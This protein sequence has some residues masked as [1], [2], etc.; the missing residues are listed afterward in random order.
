MAVTTPS[1]QALQAVPS[2]VG[3]IEPF[4]QEVVSHL[5]PVVHD[6]PGRGRPRILPAVVLWSGLLVCI[7]RGF[8]SQLALWRLLSQT[9]L[10]DYPRFPITDQAVYRRL[11]TD[12]IAPLEGLFRQ[13]TAL[14]ATRLDALLPPPEQRLAPFARDV[15]ALDAVRLDPV[16][17]DLSAPGD[18]PTGRR[19]PGQLGTLFDLRRQQWRH[20]R[21]SADADQNEKVVA[22]DLLDGLARG[23]LILAD[24]GY[25]G[26]R[27]FDELTDA[28]Y[29]WVSRLRHKTSYEVVAVLAQHGETLDALV[30][31]GVYR[32][33]RAKH[34]VRLVQ[35]R[36]GG[37][38]RRY[39]TNVRDPALLPAAEVARLYARRW[40]IELAFKLLKREVG[41]CLWWST[42][43][44]VIQQQLLGALILS[45]IILA[46]R[47]EVAARAQVDVFDVSLPLLVRYLPQFAAQGEDPL[48]A[49][50]RGGLAAG[51]IR[52]ARRVQIAVPEPPLAHAV[53]RVPIPI[54]RS[55]RYAERRC[56]P[57][58]TTVTAISWN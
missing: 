39:L 8:S 31:L 10:W 5:E 13:V 3:E 12:G 58:S 28:G 57:R 20:L 44:V 54:R 53:A 18:P 7:A 19:L 38:L 56:E 15:V 22:R 21:W 46:L 6:P 50:V 43:D 32:A 36:Q 35:F 48:D 45:Q 2:V 24:L 41:I 17:R 47:V 16:A 55:P 33:D 40:D 29:W 49:F 37:V 9:R 1:R 14:L 51:F 42:K 23:T 11:A 4:L 26:F 30:W 52:P 27:W 34:L 25:F